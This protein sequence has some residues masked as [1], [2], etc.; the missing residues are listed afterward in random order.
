MVRPLYW[1]DKTVPGSGT[2]LSSLNTTVCVTV[3]GGP[4]E[5]FTMSPRSLGGIVRRSDSFESSVA[6][7][8]A[9][10]DNPPIVFA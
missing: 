2:R 1:R 4:T 3:V 5:S 9:R 6:L 7:F 8:N 10:S